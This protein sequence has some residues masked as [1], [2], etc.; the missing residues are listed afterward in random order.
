MVYWDYFQVYLCA[1][2]D[3]KQKD[4]ILVECKLF[5]VVGILNIRDNMNGSYGSQSWIKWD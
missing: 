1:D 4:R 2:K 5:I 3:I